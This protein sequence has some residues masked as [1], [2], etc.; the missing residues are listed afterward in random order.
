MYR[1][2]VLSMGEPY[3]TSPEMI[4]KTVAATREAGIIVVGDHGVFRRVAADLSM[5]LPFT[6]Y[7]ENEDDLR[8]AEARGERFIFLISSGIREEF[9]YGKTTAEGGE[10]IFRAVQAAVALIQNG[11]GQSLVTC[12][13]TSASLSA[14]G[15]KEKTVHDLLRRFA[16]TDRLENMIF[17]GEINAFGITHRR[18]VLSALSQ[19]TRENVLEAIIKI[20]ALRV[21]SYFDKEKPLGVCS[22]NPSL[23][24]GSWTGE[25]EE[26]AI[27]PAIDI[28]KKLGINVVGPV[29]AEELFADAARGKYAAVLV[30]TS[31]VA[32][33]ACAAA[34][35]DETLLISWGLPFLR[36]GLI[37]SSGLDIAGEGRASIKAMMKAVSEALILRDSSFMA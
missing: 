15:Y 23:A 10:A 13:I 3:G 28:A 18:S 14:A 7:A 8:D 26:K 4:M 21:S 19:I 32:F 36:I 31:S 9:G 1:Y 24:D 27:I 33:A 35:P 5:P 29:A 34:S 2:A 37:G 16:K 11:L 6:Y 30:M 17:S 25:E 22:L 20:D 12:P